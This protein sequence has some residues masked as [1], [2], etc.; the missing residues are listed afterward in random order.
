VLNPRLYG[1]GKWIG[2]ADV[3]TKDFAR[4]KAPI[5]R[6]YVFE[7]VENTTTKLGMAGPSSI[8]PTLRRWR[9]PFAVLE[10]R[11]LVGLKTRVLTRHQRL[12]AHIYDVEV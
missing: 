3:I 12:F 8:S 11:A 9:P 6:V 2:L 10:V 1:L 5:A 4:L 7:E